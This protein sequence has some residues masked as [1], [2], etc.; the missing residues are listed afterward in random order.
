MSAADAADP[1]AVQPAP[2]I[3]VDLTALVE[4]RLRE[5]H[6]VSPG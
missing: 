3:S 2:T 4:E 1:A 6:L 5:V